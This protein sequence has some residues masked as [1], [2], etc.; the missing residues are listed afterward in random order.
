MSLILWQKPSTNADISL[1]TSQRSLSASS[2][3]VPNT[4]RRPVDVPIH[5]ELLVPNVHSAEI[6][7]RDKIENEC[8][9]A[10]SSGRRRSPEEYERV[11]K[12]CFDLCLFNFCC[13]CCYHFFCDF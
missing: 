13:C 7:N 1:T 12:Q 5:K 4:D 3:S 2:G 11:Q 9:N 10:Y 8:A 6:M